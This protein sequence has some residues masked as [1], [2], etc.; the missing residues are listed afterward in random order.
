MAK[1]LSDVQPD[2]VSLVTRGAN[3]RPFLF[4][5]GDEDAVIDPQLADALESTAG[6]GE[7]RLFKALQDAGV[8]A[9][10]GMAAIAAFRLL[11]T[12]AEKLPEELRATVAALSGEEFTPAPAP[13]PEPAPISKEDKPVPSDGVPFKKDDGSWDLSSVPEEQR[14][15][16]EVVLKMHDAETA[17]LNAELAA[18]DERI[19][20]SEELAQRERDLREDREY[21]AKAEAL[22]KLPQAPDEL[23]PILKSIAHA[24]QAGAI[25]AGTSEKVESILKAANEAVGQGALFSELGARGEL[26]SSDA[27]A[28]IEKAAE[29]L[30]EADPSLTKQQAIAKALEADPELYAA[31]RAEEG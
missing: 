5:K 4:A 18:R 12:H 19:Q 9:E 1:R 20:K 13:E 27:E 10:P 22:D 25:T 11:K 17:R 30:R 23:A 8:D 7:E 3:R 2:E 21:L 6:A 24:E 26:G 28:R 31:Y 14:A 16:L 29:K 15:G